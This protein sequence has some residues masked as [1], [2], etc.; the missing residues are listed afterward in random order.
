MQISAKQGPDSRVMVK[1]N[2]K[3]GDLSQVEAK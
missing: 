2:T 1:L 3:V